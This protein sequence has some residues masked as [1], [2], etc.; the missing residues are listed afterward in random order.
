MALILWQVSES[1]ELTYVVETHCVE[2]K[3]LLRNTLEEIRSPFV[4][5][6]A[7]R[8]IEA[9]GGVL[10]APCTDPGKIR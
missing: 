5:R 6:G 2:T 7:R 10:Q 3:V 4:R 9:G 8:H 1:D